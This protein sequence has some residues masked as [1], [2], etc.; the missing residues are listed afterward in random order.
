M[1]YSVKNIDAMIASVDRLGKASVE[2]FTAAKE[3]DNASYQQASFQKYKERLEKVKEA[4]DSGDINRKAKAQE[5][6]TK[7]LKE[8]TE[9]VSTELPRRIA[10]P[11]EMKDTEKKITLEY[12]QALAAYEALDSELTDSILEGIFADLS[13]AT[14]APV[15]NKEG[16]A[17]EPD[18]FKEIE[19]LMAQRT[20][21][22]SG[23]RSRATSDAGEASN[24]SPASKVD[25]KMA[26]LAAVN[27]MQEEALKVIRGINE[28]IEAEIQ[29]L[30]QILKEK[31]EKNPPMGKFT[32][33]YINMAFKGTKAVLSKAE[34][35]VAQ[36]IKSLSKFITHLNEQI[37]KA[38]HELGRGGEV[39]T[40]I[41]CQEYYES[42]QKFQQTA[43]DLMINKKTVTSH[44]VLMSTGSPLVNALDAMEKELIALSKAIHAG[45]VE[46]NDP[47]LEAA[48]TLTEAEVR[49]KFTRARQLLGASNTETQGKQTACQE[50]KQYYD[51]EVKPMI[52]RVAPSLGM[53]SGVANPE[54]KFTGA[55]KRALDKFENEAKEARVNLV[56]VISG[57]AP[58]GPDEKQTGVLP[59]PGL[60]GGLFKKK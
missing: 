13:S 16:S 4:L 33:D 8:L 43:A 31:Y 44:P 56:A 29:K 41:Y 11:N 2:L 55:Y 38:N 25:P 5:V 34:V 23:S 51:G 10:I 52:N 28:R 45:I 54:S 58:Q 22:T 47:K 49:A 3:A 30:P 26:A 39:N 42:I 50:L 53:G 20:A 19:R 7:I 48:F 27:E 18:T 59:K 17:N 9:K 1:P 35:D 12:N 6:A 57:P 46:K 24:I 21:S 14:G 36:T 60:L 40:S 32:E 15:S 37:G